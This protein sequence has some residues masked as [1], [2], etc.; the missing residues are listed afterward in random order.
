MVWNLA[1]SHPSEFTGFIPISGTFWLMP[2]PSCEGPANSIVHIHGT[3]DRTVPLDGRRI[4]ETKQG[5]VATA[6]ITYER[7]GDFGAA[8]SYETDAL[9]C[10][11]RAN[12]AGEIL[13]LCLFDGGHSFRTEYLKHGLDRLAEAGRL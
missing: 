3:Q 4:R 9:R 10:E 5:Q 8:E 7:F 13:D 1:C 6:L 12:P 2:P 11:T